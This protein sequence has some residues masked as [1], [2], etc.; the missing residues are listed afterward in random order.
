MISEALVLP[1]DHAAA[2]LATVGGKGA[3]LA[4]LAG[5]GLPVPPG[6]HITTRAYRDFV[7]ADGLAEQI[8][9]ALGGLDPDDLAAVARAAAAIAAAFAGRE[10][11]AATANA[12]GEAYQGMPVAVRSS[13]TAEDLPELSFAGQHDTFLNI[14]G[15]DAVLD[16]VKRC[17]ASLWTARAIGYRA[18]NGIA[19][20]E[21]ALA[22]VVQQQV[23]ADAAGVLFTAN[24]LTGARGELVINAGWG[25]GESVVGGQVTPDT[26]VLASGTGEELLRE[27]N[28]KTVRTVG[29]TTGTREEPVPAELRHE[30][31]LDKESAAELAGLGERIQKLYGVPMDV[32]WA[33]HNGQ[34]A[35]LQARPIT[36]LGV[37]TEVWN[38]SVIGD[39]LWTSG[40]VG[41]AVPSV[42]TPLTWSVIQTLAMPAIGGHPTSGNIGGRF[43]LNL[44]VS[45]SVGAA[46]GAGKT[47]RQ[48]NEQLLGR[49]P[50]GIE[51][52]RLPLSRPGLLRAAAPVVMLFVRQGLAYRK[53]LAGLLSETP[54]RCRT[55]HERILAAGDPRALRELWR[56]DLDS[57]LREDCQILDVGARQLGAVRTGSALRDLVGEADANTLLAGLHSGSDELASLGPLIGLA[58]LRRGEIDRDT[59]ARTWGHRCPDEFEL[60]APRPAEDPAWLDRQLG[61]VDIDPEILLARQ[62]KARDEAWERL[63]QR[64]PR[65]AARVRRR[66]DRA[67]A[68]A[69]GRERARSEMVRTF[70]VLRAFVVRAGELT[71]HGDDLFFLSLNEILT[72]LDGDAAPLDAVPAR[73]AAYRRYRALPPY[74]TM[75]RGHFDPVSWAADPD[76]R[77]DVFDETAPHKPMG[78]EI[79]GFPGAAGIVLGTARVVSTVEEGEALWPGEILVTVVT[80]VGWTP[81][82]PRAA[83]IVTDVGAPLS[84]AAIVAR[85]LGIPAVVGCGNATT[86]LSTGDRVRV[87]GAA[88]TVVIV[89]EPSR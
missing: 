75:I 46:L 58:R 70:G 69:R 79:S 36:T 35:I 73:R 57:L 60:S 30:P 24:P 22:V 52:P 47:I 34:F 15:E 17:W 88:G 84:H 87:D 40:N 62:V 74:P 25:L 83:A 19:P 68:A 50:E 28:D 51:V 23:P 20:D 13:A 11:P 45:H 63:R 42:M 78:D 71:G 54:E 1:L 38:D 66:L 3:S 41:E 10:L 72:V 2:D 16:A 27:V 55:L 5:A 89:E 82:F 64:Y 14:T 49:I 29:D 18:R 33:I 48:T 80:N 56:S 81:L 59:Y 6:F 26:Y 7:A 37:A 43:Y 31:V 53:R 9:V 85:E 44:S 39:Y 77:A 76:R 21:V 67:A 86:R 32:E 8:T 65:K 12:I 4:R 61:D